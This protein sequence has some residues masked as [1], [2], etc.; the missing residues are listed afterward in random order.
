MS[1]ITV[2]SPMY[3]EGGAVAGTALAERTVP[4]EPVTVTIVENAK[5]NAKQLLGY[6]AEGLRDRFAVAEIIVH[7]KPTAGKPIDAEDAE[8]LA[9]RS[10]MVISGLGD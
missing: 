4:T 3:E 5:P 8:R 10:H 2:L 9:A 1:T 7:S 6:I